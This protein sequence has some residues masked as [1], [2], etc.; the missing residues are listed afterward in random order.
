MTVL[1]YYQFKPFKLIYIFELKYLIFLYIYMYLLYIQN[2]TKKGN[3][4][5]YKKEDL[6]NKQCS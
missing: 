4:Q 5:I 2:I 3:M 6:N 1:A